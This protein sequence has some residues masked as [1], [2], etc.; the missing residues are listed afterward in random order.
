MRHN[1]QQLSEYQN[2]NRA[3][4]LCY[5]KNFLFQEEEWNLLWAL[6]HYPQTPLTKPRPCQHPTPIP[7]CSR[8]NMGHSLPWM[9]WS[10]WDLE[11]SL[12]N[13]KRSTAVVNMDK[14]LFK[15][16]QWSPYFELFCVTCVILYRRVQ[17]SKLSLLIYH[18]YLA[19]MANIILHFF[20]CIF[21]IK[22]S[23]VTKLPLY[24]PGLSGAI[25]SLPVT[26]SVDCF[27]F[28]FANLRGLED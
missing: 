14:N 21:T 12:K 18:V 26:S 1:Y 9:E 4:K 28:P 23:F 5:T 24:S 15:T 16:N 2:Q 22:T 13:R 3:D 27:N 25:L 10:Y 19:K 11:V 7:R 8:L 20:N 6:D 17:F